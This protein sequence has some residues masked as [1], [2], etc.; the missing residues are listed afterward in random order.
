V[1]LLYVYADVQTAITV[2]KDPVCSVNNIQEKI[3]EMFDLM[4]NAILL[5]KRTLK[6]V[7]NTEN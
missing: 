6:L 3:S 1:K 4:V 7:N 5:R 2:I